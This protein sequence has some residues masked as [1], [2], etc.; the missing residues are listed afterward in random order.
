MIYKKSLS[1][2]EDFME[3]FKNF[4]KIHLG[5]ILIES[6]L[7]LI[8]HLL[9]N[10]LIFNLYLF[11]SHLK[12]KTRGKNNTSNK[13]VKKFKLSNRIKV[14]LNGDNLYKVKVNNV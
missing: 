7:I 2:K 10:G 8:N 6:G 14:N 1:N 9:V 11:Q 4:K 5:R 13:I 12:L 3:L